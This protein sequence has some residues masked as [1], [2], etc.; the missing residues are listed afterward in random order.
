VELSV[1]ASSRAAPRRRADP[2]PELDPLPGA[3]RLYLP[4]DG[5]TIWYTVTESPDGQVVIVAPPICW[6]L[7]TT[8]DKMIPPAAQRVMS[9][10]AGEVP[11]LEGPRSGWAIGKCRCLAAC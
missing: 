10:R 2:F 6:Y 8:E 11:V 5:L 4:S 1:L 9:G 3:Y 7:L